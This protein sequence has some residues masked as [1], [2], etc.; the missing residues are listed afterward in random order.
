MK[1]HV[2][3]CASLL[4]PQDKPRD[5]ALHVEYLEQQINHCHEE[6]VQSSCALISVSWDRIQGGWHVHAQRGM[7]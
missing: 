5:E 3:A 2:F 4:F 6:W 1:L 7:E